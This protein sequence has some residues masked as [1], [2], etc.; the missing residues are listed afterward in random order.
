MIQIKNQLFNSL[1][2]TSFQGDLKDDELLRLIPFLE[3][4]AEVNDFRPVDQK[5]KD[6]FSGKNILDE[7]PQ[8]LSKLVPDFTKKIKALNLEEIR[9]KHHEDQID[10]IM[11]SRVPVMRCTPSISSRKLDLKSICNNKSSFEAGNASQIVTNDSHRSA[12]KKSQ[13]YDIDNSSEFSD[14]INEHDDDEALIIP[15]TPSLS[16]RTPAVPSTTIS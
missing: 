10:D 12:A 6:Y 8:N 3:N 13:Y 16:K 11:W 14:N 7:P 5:C 2:I 4:L 1:L 9:P 15:V